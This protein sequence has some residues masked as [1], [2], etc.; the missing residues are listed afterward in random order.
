MPKY[1]ITDE[2]A[3]NIVTRAIEVNISIIRQKIPATMTRDEKN[4]LRKEKKEARTWLLSEGYDFMELIAPNVVNRI[5]KDDWFYRVVM[6][7]PREKEGGT[8][9]GLLFA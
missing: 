7:C 6:N 3:A 4:E 9:Q 1:Y 5:S 2:Q 8:V